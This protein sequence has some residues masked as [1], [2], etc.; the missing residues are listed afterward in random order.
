MAV[1][2]SSSGT[3]YTVFAINAE[4]GDSIALAS[5]DS[6]NNY[7]F[8]MPLAPVWVYV[9]FQSALKLFRIVT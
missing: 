5:G 1:N 6:Q 4:T 2:K 9:K 7:T 8:T 3:V